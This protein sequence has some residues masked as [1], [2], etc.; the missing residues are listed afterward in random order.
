MPVTES[1]DLQLP[2][3][4]PPPT[5][6]GDGDAASDQSGQSGAA[7]AAAAAD[8][9]PPEAQARCHCEGLRELA[10][11]QGAARAPRAAGAPPR[12][13]SGGIGVPE[14]AVVVLLRRALRL[15]EDGADGPVK[16]SLR[17]RFPGAGRWVEEGLL[18]YL[19]DKSASYEKT[20]D[21]QGRYRA[22]TRTC[23]T[24]VLASVLKKDGLLFAAARDEEARQGVCDDAFQIFGVRWQ[25]AHPELFPPPSVDAVQ[26]CVAKMLRVLGEL[27][28]DVEAE[29]CA[30][31]LRELERELRAVVQAM[32]AAAGPLP[33]LLAAQEARALRVHRALG[34]WREAVC[35]SAAELA[36]LGVTDV[37]RKLMARGA[38]GDG[39]RAPQWVRKHHGFSPARQL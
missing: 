16:A 32:A 1:G 14:Y 21:G 27:G 10:E 30:L 13:P 24:H 11:A 4:P 9:A 35:A 22:E 37:C 3:A 7:A 6:G 38:G 36:G 17:A 15:F 23:D 29:P 31:C 28:V 34:A 12:P 8:A 39:R 25:A 2:A 19:G 26:T 33:V 18:P 5:G 20:K